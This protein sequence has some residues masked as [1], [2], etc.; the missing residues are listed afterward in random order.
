MSVQLQLSAEPPPKIELYSCTRVERKG[1]GTKIGGTR[2]RRVPRARLYCS[3]FR[4]Q[5]ETVLIRAQLE[6]ICNGPY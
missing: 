2:I 3:N 6:S 4:L 5:I 1:G